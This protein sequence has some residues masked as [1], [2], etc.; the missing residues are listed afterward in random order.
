MKNIKL[1]A[2]LMLGV[3]FNL[4]TFDPLKN[5]VRSF[6]ASLCGISC[7]VEGPSESQEYPS[8]NAFFGQL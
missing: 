6:F 2:R 5:K 4:M 7:I 3:D 1:M 8:L